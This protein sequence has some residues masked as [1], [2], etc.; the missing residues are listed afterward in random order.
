MKRSNDK[1]RIF[2]LLKKM[3]KPV[4]SDTLCAL[5]HVKRKERA[6][7][8]LALKQMEKAGEITRD[9]KGRYVIA[10]KKAPLRGR[11]LSLSDG[12]AFA[13]LDDGRDCFIPGRYLN[14]AMPGDIVQIEMGKPNERGPHGAV[15]KIEQKG[16]RLYTG[17]LA[18]E[19]GEWIVIPDRL[20]RFA[21]PLKRSKNQEYTV[22]D[23]VRFSLQWRGEYLLATV[24]TS[25]GSADSARI[26]ADAIID[27][28]G[29]PTEFPLPVLEQAEEAARAGITESDWENREDLRDKTIFTIDGIDA[30]D[31]DDAISLEP[32]EQGGWILGVHI[33]DVSHYVRYATPLDTEAIAR[34]TSVY[35]ADRVI[36]MLPEALSNGACS[37]NAGEDKLTFSAFMTY[38]SQGNCID[39]RLTKSVIRSCVRGVYSE[40][41]ALFD[42]SASDEIQKKYQPVAEILRDMRRL[43][44][45]LRKKACERG[46]LDLVSVET[47][48]RLDENGVPIEV[49]PRVSGEAEELIEQFMIAANEQVA[50]FARRERI[51]FIYRVHDKPNKEK[52][53]M[54]L[55]SVTMLG[56]KT[57]IKA[58]NPTP[59]E[60]RDLVEESKET[61]YARLISMQL[62][63][64]MAKAQY[65][66]KPLGHYGLGLEDYSHF[67]SPIRR[68]PDLAIHRILTSYLRNKNP[69]LIT[70]RFSKFVASASVQSS[71]C[72]VRAQTAERDC[73]ACYKAEYMSQ[74][75]G[76][77]FDGVISSVSNFGIYVELD[78]SIE[79]MIRLE[80]LPQE[81]LEFDGMA[82][83]KD[84][85]DRTLYKVGDPMKIS[86]ASCEISSGLVG[87]VP[88]L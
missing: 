47:R 38:N 15:V 28:A 84:N 39:S 76:E 54:L 67:T 65:S 4:S 21:V 88:V 72:E 74:F 1:S 56:L 34:G 46:N 12:F 31:L 11:M 2:G 73:E 14:D 9:K 23:K 29:I 80:Y 71:E 7:I 20:I 64:C 3:T 33:A 27:D 49:I 6:Y 57:E 50:A 44:D 81:D 25:Y 24:Q 77:E 79:G 55:Q 58:D 41:N 13:R 18:E 8:L 19:H 16:E 30:K 37:L 60:L 35:F 68:Y 66:E 42:S 85:M 32:T 61:P 10:G 48:F 86:V 82:S 36:P 52:L 78:N 69:E 53:A 59:T 45:K 70:A 5:L 83:L 51:P 87:F 75:I 22:G 62:L 40:V 63:R 17:R 43:A 26:C